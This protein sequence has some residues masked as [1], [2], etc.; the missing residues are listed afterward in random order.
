MD[1]DLDRPVRPEDFNKMNSVAIFMGPLM[2]MYGTVSLNGLKPLIGNVKRVTLLDVNIEDAFKKKRVAP[3]ASVRGRGIPFKAVNIPVGLIERD[4]HSLISEDDVV[5][6]YA[7][8]GIG[9]PLS[10]VAADK[11][12]TIGYEK[13]LRFD[14]TAGEWQEAGELIEGRGI[15]LR[16]AA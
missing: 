6:I 12:F 4:A 9:S 3:L 10:A 1:T 14:G 5:V 2:D 13:L 16:K 7:E 15:A 8:G 11:L